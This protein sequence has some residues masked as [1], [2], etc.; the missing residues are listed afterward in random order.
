MKFLEN[1]KLDKWYALVLYLGAFFIVASLYFTIDFLE[2]AHLFGLGLGMVL[3]GL[4]FLIAEKTLS[5]IK[6]PN[7]YTG[8]TA[9]FSWKE[10]HHN[11]FTAT[12]LIIGL[13]LVCIFG[14]LI[15]KSLI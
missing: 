4:S 3:V 6:S 7:A 13:L 14:F 15:V 1:L 10:I 11:F 5:V 8:G 12:L 2:E 9:L